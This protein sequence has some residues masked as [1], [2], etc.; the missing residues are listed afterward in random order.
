MRRERKT[1]LEA[2]QVPGNEGKEK[3]LPTPKGEESAR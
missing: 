1:G 2:K 3:A